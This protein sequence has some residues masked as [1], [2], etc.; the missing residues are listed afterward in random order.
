MGG[1][2]IINSGMGAR[3]PCPGP[4]HIRRYILV[5]DNISKKLHVSNPTATQILS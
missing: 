3:E 2:Q 4:T 5:G 1:F